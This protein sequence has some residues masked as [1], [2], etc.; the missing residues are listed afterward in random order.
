MLPDSLSRESRRVLSRATRDWQP[1]EPVMRQ[2]A[3]FVAPGLALRMY[4]RHRKTQLT[5][6]EM[7]FT[8]A[9]ILVKR[10]VI[11][12]RRRGHIE[13][14]TVDCVRMYRLVSHQPLEGK[15]ALNSG[16]R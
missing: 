16:A 7:L 5:R 9:M 8:G 1:L 13:T 3:A 12:L 14:Q 4:A 6:D 10:R 15:N 2:A 11:D